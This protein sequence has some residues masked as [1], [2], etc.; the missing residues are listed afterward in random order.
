[1]SNNI[2]WLII[3]LLT[4]SA[5]AADVPFVF[6]DSAV[7]VA[8]Y[9]SDQI[10]QAYSTSQDL[11]GVPQ[12]SEPKDSEV[13]AFPITGGSS[14]PEG[15]VDEKVGEL[16]IILNA[17]VE[18]D[19]RDIRHAAL[20]LAGKHPGDYTIEQV[21]CIY[22]YLKGGDDAT[23][24]WSY[25]RDPRGVDYFANASESL[26][27]GKEIGCSGIGD[28][29]DFAILMS[30]LVECVG[31]TTRIVLARNNTT[32]GHAYTE[33]YLGNFSEKSNH[34]EDIIS[35][36]KQ[37]HG[38]DKI[39]THIDTDTK[40]V[41]LNLDWGADDKGNAHPGGP[42]FQGDKHIVLCLRDKYGKS[43]IRLPEGYV[44]RTLPSV[45]RY[46]LIA[47][48]GNLSNPKYSVAFTPDGRT[49]AAGCGNGTVMLW[50]TASGSEIRML[51]GH[52]GSV[53]SVAFSPDSRILAS[54]S[55]D[56]S[57]KLWNVESGSE[58]QTLE[59]HYDWGVTS[60]AFSPDGRTLASGSG[61]TTVKLWD[62]ASGSE[63]RTL[64]GHSYVVTSVA[65]SP[66]SRTL[67]SSSADR[68]VKLW[69]VASGSEIRTQEGHS[70]VVHSVAFSPDGRTLASGS[71]DRTVKLWDVA[72]GSEIRTQEGHSDS[73]Y[74]VAF[75]PDGRTLASG[76]S[77][78]TVKL[79]DTA[80]GSE[81]RTLEGH[82]S[83][84]NSVAFSPDGRIL[85]SA[86]YDGTIR[87]WQMA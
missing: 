33:V 51:D 87:L 38:T 55:G 28:C 68:T 27:T 17:R 26:N 4:G 78:T 64:V 19:N 3:I 42:F 62:T 75:S 77:D 81:I 52:S 53:S 66:D 45:E 47:V 49:L 15:T 70:N 71:G 32:G 16:K 18:P 24:G 23:E 56:T 39:Y 41:W 54:G 60:V 9:T 10:R 59:G 14:I 63:I 67:A 30:A 37:K 82:S 58:I 40:N 48:L 50:D 22:S 6:D 84:V 8:S 74:G 76:S 31:G 5:V 69:D 72:S 43:P 21:D 7:D 61:D 73:V 1:M 85:A 29:D 2:I 25:V 44:V 20:L 46:G 57:V 86:S 83:A 11:E 36:L 80:N 12:I 79:W 35:W 13:L 34:V 65:F